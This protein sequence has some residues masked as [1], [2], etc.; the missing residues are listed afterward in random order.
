ME[1]RLS[2][3]WQYIRKHWVATIIIVFVGLIVLIVLGYLFKWDWTGFNNGTSQITITSPSNGNYNAT[4][5]QP[6]KS[7]WD[8]L[9]LLAVLAMP[10]VVGFGVAWFTAQQG[11]VSD[12]ENKDNQQETELQAYIN[13]MSELILEKK[14]YV[15]GPQSEDAQKIARVRTLTVLRGLDS[16]RKAS[17]LQFLSEAGLIDKYKRIIDLSEAQLLEANLFKAN[18]RGAN[19]SKVNLSR[20]D[21]SYSNLLYTILRGADLSSANLS[22]ANLRFANLREINLVRADLTCARLVRV[23]LYGAKLCESDLSGSDLSESD[24]ENANVSGA[25]LSGAKLFKTNL[26]CAN[27]SNARLDNVD[28]EGANLKDAI[29]ITIDEL[30]KQAKSLKGATMPDGSIHP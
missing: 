11:K 18:L 3:W 15:S 17:V 8:W 30:E 22:N 19:L 2:S 1:A 27:L 12:R 13:A 10:V 26:K 9:Q 4:V 7:L 5:S 28:L 6:S 24:L 25:D 20:A 16:T 23:K 21:L 14:L 29:G